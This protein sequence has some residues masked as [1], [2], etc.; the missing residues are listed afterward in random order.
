MDSYKGMKAYKYEFY[1]IVDEDVD[2]DTV[3][4]GIYED[5]TSG[6]FDMLGWYPIGLSYVGDAT[7]ECE[8]DIDYL[9][10]E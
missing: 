8:S 7:D 9:V 3:E 1:V 10:E 4:D 6:A 5:L 2:Y